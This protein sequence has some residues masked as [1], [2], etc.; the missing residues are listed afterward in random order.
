MVMTMRL[1]EANEMRAGMSRS[2]TSDA[3]PMSNPEP[4]IVTRPRPTARS[5]ITEVTAGTR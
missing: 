4:L 1:L 3:S 5:G 2:I